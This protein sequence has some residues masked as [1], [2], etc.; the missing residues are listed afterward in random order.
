MIRFKR[1]ISIIVASLTLTLSSCAPNNGFT[2]I[3]EGTVSGNELV[4]EINREKCQ[5][6]IEMLLQEFTSTNFCIKY[7]EYESIQYNFT[8]VQGLESGPVV[9]YQFPP[10]TIFTDRNINVYYLAINTTPFP[11]PR[12]KTTNWYLSF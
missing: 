3:Y 1:L 9:L 6:K 7:V 11:N 5:L 8:G 10:E 4:V 12:L 2:L